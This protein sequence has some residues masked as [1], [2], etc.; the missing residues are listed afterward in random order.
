MLHLWTMVYYDLWH[1]N[2]NW[3]KIYRHGIDTISRECWEKIICAWHNIS[4]IWHN[5]S[6]SHDILWNA[7]TVLCDSIYYVLWV[8][9]YMLWFR[10][11]MLWVC[12]Y[13]LWFRH[14]TLF[15]YDNSSLLWSLFFIMITFLYV[16]SSLLWWLFL[17][18]WWG[19]ISGS[20]VPVCMHATEIQPWNR[21]C[22][23]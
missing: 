19:K 3:K 4:C 8:C 18:T 22:K 23:I 1:A 10:H 12:H 5:L 9:H 14:Y 16:N 11:Y 17:S 7:I 21:Y 15:L 2:I 20:S 13:V 6:N